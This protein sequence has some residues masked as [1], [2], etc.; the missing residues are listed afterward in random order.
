MMRL[1]LAKCSFCLSLFLISSPAILFSLRHFCPN[2][3]LLSLGN[4]NRVF[5]N[6]FKNKMPIKNKMEEREETWGKMDGKKLIYFADF[7][8]FQTA[9]WLQIPT[10]ENFTAGIKFFRP[11]KTKCKSPICRARWARGLL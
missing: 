2:H 3:T 7:L 10:L 6:S 4:K 11:E 8:H 5:H 1:A 9:W